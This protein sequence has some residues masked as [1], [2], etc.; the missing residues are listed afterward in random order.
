MKPHESHKA[1]AK[2]SVAAAVVTVSDSRTVETD[3]SGAV[4]REAL[5]AAGHRVVAYDIVPD[6]PDAVGRLLDA[7]VASAGV[8]AVILDGGTGLA[9]RDNTYEVVASRLTKTLDGFGE[10]F[11]MLSFDDIGSSAMLSRAVGG[12]AADTAVFALPGSSGACRLAMDRLVVPELPH[13]V[14]LAKP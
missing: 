3:R 6:D 13:I 9:P 7:H 11:R 10:L 8:D 2:R 5:E 1:A 12:L 4:V 14:T